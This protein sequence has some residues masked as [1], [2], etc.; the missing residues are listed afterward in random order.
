MKSTKHQHPSSRET[1]MAGIQTIL[2]R[3]EVS[4]VGCSGPG[5]WSLKLGIFL[6]LGAWNL[7][8]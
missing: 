5:D 7:E 1:S 6:E 2:L 3:D 8:L 4:T